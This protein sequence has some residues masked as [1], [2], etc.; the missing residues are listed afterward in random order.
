MTIHTAVLIETLKA[1]SSDL[2]WFYFKK[3]STQDQ[4]VDVIAYDESAAVF[5]WKGDIL[6]EYWYCILN[7]LIQIE[8]DGKGHRPDLIFD[9]GGYMTLLIHEGKKS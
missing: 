9:D 5:S 3:K 6:E 7:A 1:L 4:T 8:D 2:C